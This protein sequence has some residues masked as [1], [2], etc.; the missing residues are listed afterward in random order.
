MVTF[1]LFF[2]SLLDGIIVFSLFDE[3]DHGAIM[4]YSKSSGNPEIF[5]EISDV[6]FMNYP[7]KR[8]RESGENFL[9]TDRYATGG[10]V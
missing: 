6:F 1:S 4:P 5:N 2:V 3:P 7:A 8:T 9:L 10:G